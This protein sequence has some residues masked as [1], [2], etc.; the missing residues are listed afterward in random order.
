MQLSS[1]DASGTPAG[2]HA[3]SEQ[4]SLALG[5][6]VSLAIAVLGLLTYGLSGSEAV[7]LDGLYAGVMALTS[8]VAARVGANVVRPPDRGW[9]FGYEGQEAVYVLLRSLLLLGILSFAGLNAARDLL[10]WWQGDTPEA[11]ASGP[12]GW[13]GLL[14]GLSC[15]ALAW[16]Q[17]RSWVAG[18][19]CSELLRTESRAALLDTAITGGTGAVLM[20]APLL[21]STPL[22]PLVPVADALL[23]LVLALVVAGEPLHRFRLALRET[24]GA[25]CEPELI[26]NTRCG[27][28]TLVEAAT[29]QLLDLSVVKLGR[30]SYVVAYVNPARAVEASWLD[31]LRDQ[32]EERCTTLLGP[33]RAEVVLTGRPPFSGAVAAG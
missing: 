10:A 28:Q 15:G 17:H 3:L 24:A 2:D 19:R 20:A 18:G 32:L 33:V 27:V 1:R 16:A 30:I 12:V 23:V 13:Y 6:W 14:G 29:A 9:P 26:Q 22:A 7:L 4:R 31:G 21:S 8:L 5:L 25:A 11:I